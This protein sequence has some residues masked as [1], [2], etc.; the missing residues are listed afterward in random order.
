MELFKIRVLVQSVSVRSFGFSFNHLDLSNLASMVREYFPH[1]L[2]AVELSEPTHFFYAAVGINA[3]HLP[4]P[5]TPRL[6]RWEYKSATLPA[7]LA[8]LTPS[9]QKP[10]IRAPDS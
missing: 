1:A 10:A 8:H 5:V 7:R 9:K 6:T 3:I 2:L 4:P